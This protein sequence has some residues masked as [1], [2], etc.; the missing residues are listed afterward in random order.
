MAGADLLA[1]GN[2][3]GGLRPA[4]EVTTKSNILFGSI[5]SGALD[6]QL[7]FRGYLETKAN[8]DTFRKI[9]EI[10][11]K[12]P[13]DLVDIKSDEYQ[14]LE[15]L[16]ELINSKVDAFILQKR[17][18][19]DRYNNIKTTYEIKR[20]IE[21]E[22]KF[23]REYVTRQKAG[24]GAG[25]AAVGFAGGVIGSFADPIN[26]ASMFMGFGESKSVLSYMAKE[27]GLNAAI[28]TAQIPG[29]VEWENRLGY[30]YGLKEAA[31]DIAFAGAA[32][33]VF[34]G[35]S[36]G[37]SKGVER[38]YNFSK[39]RSVGQEVFDAVA[40]DKTMPIE[41]R[42]NAANM[43][44]IAHIDENNPI[45][46]PTIG[47]VVTHRKNMVE[48]ENAFK[49][50]RNPEVTNEPVIDSYITKA[51]AIRAEITAPEMTAEKILGHKP[52]S[53]AQ[54]IKETGGIQDYAGELKA[55]DVSHKSLVGL[56]RKGK[57]QT[58]T[59]QGIVSIDNTTDYVK[60]RVFDAGYFPDKTDYN[61]ISDSELYDAIARDVSGDKVYKGEDNVKLQEAGYGRNAIDKYDEIGIDATMSDAEIAARLRELS[62]PDIPPKIENYSEDFEQRQELFESP[63]YHSAIEADFARE[64]KD[65]QDFTFLDDNGNEMTYDDFM[66]SMQEDED[67][68]TAIKTCAIG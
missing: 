53:L 57:A 52:K 41:V 15:K 28:E 6:S 29:R 10:E 25:G 61:D 42:E 59:A 32:G 66:S 27:A 49:E 68:L 46:N 36:R 63:E 1:L 35:I 5:Y 56:I 19:D 17:S 33:G 3:L 20:D 64:M 60:Q 62:E 48:T 13:I 50:N 2:Q 24:E 39:R 16:P 11:G 67:I 14:G 23:T 55:R 47:D 9:Q 8:K 26:A 43:S 4:D 37:I 58:Q 44:R 34:A 31:T 38:V 30:K 18:T 54:F 7:G 22:A 12:R 40:M 45:E 51:Q 21:S 65:A